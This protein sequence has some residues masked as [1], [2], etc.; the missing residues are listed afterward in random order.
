MLGEE[1]HDR[2][3]LVVKPFVHVATALQQHHLDLSLS[4]ALNKDAA[5]ECAQDD[6]DYA[7]DGG[8]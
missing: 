8:E 1:L 7:H 4:R 3:T 2:E 5:D 6:A